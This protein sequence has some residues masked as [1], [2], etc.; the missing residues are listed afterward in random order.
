[1]GIHRKIGLLHKVLRKVG[2][3]AYLLI[4]ESVDMKHFH[5][6]YKLLK[7]KEVVNGEYNRVNI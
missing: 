6:F 5:L 2:V 1:M 7:T 4:F 3:T